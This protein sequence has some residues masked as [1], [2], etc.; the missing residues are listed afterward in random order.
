M[1]RPVEMQNPVYLGYTPCVPRG[2]VLAIPVYRGETACVPRGYTAP[3]QDG[4]SCVPRVHTTRRSTIGVAVGDEAATSRSHQR[5]GMGEAAREASGVAERAAGAPSSEP[6]LTSNEAT[7]AR[8]GQ[9][10]PERNSRG[11]GQQADGEK[12]GATLMPDMVPMPGTPVGGGFGGRGL[13]FRV[14]PR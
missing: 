13:Q 11:H 2:Y 3:P 6:R 7:T 1:I 14:T 8:G 4:L 9:S 10:A 5:D 12:K